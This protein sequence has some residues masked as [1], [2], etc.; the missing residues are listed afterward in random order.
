MNVLRYIQPPDLFTIL[1]ISLGF[2][3]ILLI[4]E[5]Q[6]YEMVAA[7]VGLIIL[8]AGADGLDGFVARKM[9]SGPLGANLDS[10][11]DLVS[12]GVA[13]AFIAVQA[14]ALPLWTWT[15]AIFFLICG[16][17][18]LA[19][20]NISSKNDQLFEGLPIP[21]AGM[22]LSASVLLGRPD[23]TV[24]LMLILA[25][26]MISSI[27]YPKIKD[28]RVLALLGL[29]TIAAAWAVYF[30][31]NIVYTAI[32]VGLLIILYL[33]SPMVISRLQKGK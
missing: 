22:A 33:L 14:F 15:V 24:P 30:Q 20:F 12:F 25:L 21:A 8:A 18:R 16:A 3:S 29:F 32:L 9:G 27:P 1:N 7:A 17:L 2:L 4:R 10:L 5:S 11:A 31:S 19:R 23:I 6:S 13:P 28:I 26:L